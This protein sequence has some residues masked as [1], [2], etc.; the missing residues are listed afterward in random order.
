MAAVLGISA[1]HHDAAAALVVDGALVAAM[2]EERF[3][4]VKS[5]ASLPLRA[6]RACLAEAAL[7][8]GDLDEVVFHENPYGTLERVV[9]T[10]LRRWPR[11]V[12]RFPAALRA[13]L[14]GD[15]WVKDQLAAG[16]GVDRA[17]VTHREHHHSHAASAFLPSPFARAAVLTIDGVGGHQSTGLWLGEGAALR[18]LEG[19]DW[20]RSIGLVYSALTS[21]LGFE[22]NDGE[23]KVMGL[24]AYGRPTRVDAV[25]RLLWPTA[26]G[27][28]VDASWFDDLDPSGASPRLEAVLGPRRQRGR[29]WDVGGVDRGYAELAASLQ[30]TTEEAVLALAR[31][32]RALTG[33]SALCLA[34]GVALNAVAVGRVSREAGFDAVFVQPAAGDAGAAL[35]AALLAAADRGDPRPGLAHAAWGRAPDPGVADG[36]AAALGLCR[37]RVQDPADEVVQRLARG[38]LVGWCTGRFEWGPRA[39]GQRSLLARPAPAQVR[40]HVNAAVKRRELFRPF[41]PAVEAS[42]AGRFFEGPLEPLLTAFMTTVAPVRADAREAL[43]AVTHVD[44]SARVQTVAPGGALWG[45]VTGLGAA[46]GVPVVL[47]TSL[48]GRGEP[49][50][51]TETDAIGFFVSHPLDA[52]VIDDLLVTRDGGAT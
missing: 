14:G 28:D 2:Q 47:N 10:L 42:S 8:P 43:A 21:W 33:A 30:Q 26:D 13:Q 29:P 9:G 50:V 11:S 38:E 52:L 23:L 5:D 51:A 48:N 35:G 22:V 7:R 32:V 40:D 46:T 36:V 39:L 12:T 16:L 34:G 18:F 44:G 31:R 1:L 15:V 17:R 37:R 4:R 25:R 27:Y 24:A 3:T 20:P 19:A 45:V 6:A 41:A 49:I